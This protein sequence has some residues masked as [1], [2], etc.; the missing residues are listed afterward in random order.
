MSEIIDPRPLHG[1]PALDR[2][3]THRAREIATLLERHFQTPFH[4]VTH[5]GTP[6]GTTPAI[7]SDGVRC[8]TPK[9]PDGF[10]LS[11]VLAARE[12]HLQPIC[13]ENTIF[14]IPLCHHKTE[15]ALVGTIAA[16]DAGLAIPL[17]QTLIEN[18]DQQ[19]RLDLCAEQLNEYASQVTQDFEELSWLRSLAEMPE[20]WHPHNDLTHI[21]TEILPPLCD[22]LQVE[23]IFLFLTDAHSGSDALAFRAGVTGVS[24]ASMA[25][26]VS[27]FGV[28]AMEHPLVRNSIP[29]DQGGQRLEGIQSCVLVPI[30]INSQRFGWLV[31]VNKLARDEP[32]SD[33]LGDTALGLREFGT[34][35]AGLLQSAGVNLAAH[36]SNLQSFREIEDLVVGVIRAMINSID[37]KDP[38]TR[39]HSDRV[40]AMA[41][42]LTRQLGLP[43]QEEHHVYMAGL[44]HDIGKIGLPDAVLS[45]PGRLTDEE[46]AQ[47]KLH[48]EIGVSI[49]QHLKQLH[50]ALPG[51]LHHHE[52]FDGSGYPH[53]LA[54]EEIPLMGRILAVADA[55]DAM[56]S[57]R[58]Y[59]TGMPREKATA[60]LQAGSGQ[61]WDARIIEAFMHCAEEIN[62]VCQFNREHPDAP[63]DAACMTGFSPWDEIGFAVNSTFSQ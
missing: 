14:V 52:S 56:T 8:P 19:Q 9:L 33:A 42:V 3:Q 6:L 30:A 38:Y 62:D 31:M 7:T 37:A 15:L 11:E 61:Q 48:P 49:L 60:I 2:R 59:R 35:E 41:R 18:F 25:T 23:A 58:P 16:A 12:L 24:D 1:T 10:S 17:A 32:T 53:G 28:H 13:G 57:N 46:F 39:G 47:V 20:L 54:G 51:V 50:F 27:Q 63:L 5:D 29:M 4:L 21:A 26:L 34:F 36:A 43:K 55:Y 45:K 44:L 22:V 40:A